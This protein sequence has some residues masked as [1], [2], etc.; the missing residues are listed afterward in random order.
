MSKKMIRPQSCRKL[1]INTQN[2]KKIVR[3]QSCRKLKLKKTNKNLKYTTPVFNDL[4]LSLTLYQDPALLKL[5][6]HKQKISNKYMKN[7]KSTLDNKLSSNVQRVRKMRKQRLKR[8]L[9]L[10]K[11]Q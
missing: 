4:P 11:K 5:S 7:M 8:R 6:L 10:F 2:T 9:R 1:R 3:P